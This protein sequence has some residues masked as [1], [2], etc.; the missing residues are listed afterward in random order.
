M[1][2]SYVFASYDSLG[3]ADESGGRT[4]GTNYW[5]LGICTDYVAYVVSFS[6][7]SLFDDVTNQPFW[8]NPKSFYNWESD[9][10]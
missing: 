7:L 1:Y 9:F 5:G 10:M 3:S 6:V 2:L 8:T 4:A